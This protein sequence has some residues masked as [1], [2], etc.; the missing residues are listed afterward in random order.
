MNIAL[1]YKNRNKIY[2]GIENY[3]K[4]IIDKILHIDCNNQYFLS[5]DNFFDTELCPFSN[6]KW[7]ETMQRD[8][9]YDFMCYCKKIDIVHSYWPT[10]EFMKSRCIKIFTIH[11]VIPLVSFPTIQKHPL[12]EYFDTSVRKSALMSDLILTDSKY[13]RKDVIEYYNIAPDKIKVVYPGISN[14]LIF[15]KGNRHVLDK[16]NIRNGYILAVSTIDPRKNLRGLI[17]GFIGYKQTHKQS[18]LK[19]VLVGKKSWDNEFEKDFSK[20]TQY[21]ESIVLT[22]YISDEELSSLYQFSLA[23]AYV[24]FYEGFGLPLLEALA[25]GKAVI[26]SNATS[27]PEVCEEAACYC[28]PYDVES[29]ESAINKVVSD[30]EY[31]ENLEKKAK[32]QAAKFSYEKSAKEI[33]DIYNSFR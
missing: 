33:I 19:L 10:F 32:V 22:G 20:V 28:D 11:D 16:F 4:E 8:L 21:R 5:D 17:K 15:S 31:R 12:K 24:S 7:G 23:V 3:T 27:M 14:K 30:E 1:I 29:I 13:T 18:K 26:S 9:R 25:A 6:I 2:T